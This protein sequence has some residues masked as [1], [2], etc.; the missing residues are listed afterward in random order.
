VVFL[1]EELFEDEFSGNI[2]VSL[3][4]KS[5]GSRSHCASAISWEKAFDWVDCQRF[6]AHN[7]YKFKL[8]KKKWLSVYPRS[9]HYDKN[10]HCP[11]VSSVLAMRNSVATIRRKL[12]M[13][14]FADLMC[15]PPTYVNQIVINVLVPTS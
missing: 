2:T 10:F 9:E 1:L 12:F 5:A 6:R 7:D 11:V 4:K 13:L 3:V 14:F 15:G 8:L